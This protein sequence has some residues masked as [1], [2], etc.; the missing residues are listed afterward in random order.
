MGELKWEGVLCSMSP[1]FWGWP[2][3]CEPQTAQAASRAW[4]M[5]RAGRTLAGWWREERMP[6]AI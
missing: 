6:R 5:H 2:G 1:H 4:S 3:T